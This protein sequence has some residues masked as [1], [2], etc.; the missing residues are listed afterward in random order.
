MESENIKNVTKVDKP[1]IENFPIP[2]N[3]AFVN[4]Q[5][6]KLFLYKISAIIIINN[7]PRCLLF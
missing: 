6:Q 4:Q 2:K 5:V 3:N 1:K 7:I